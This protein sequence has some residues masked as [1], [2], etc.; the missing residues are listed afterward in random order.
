MFLSR[1]RVRYKA[2]CCSVIDIMYDRNCPR[3]VK[4]WQE[5]Q[6]LRSYWPHLF[7]IKSSSSFYM[8]IQII[9]WRNA[10]LFIIH[11][12]YLLTSF[13]RNKIRITFYCAILSCQVL[14]STFWIQRTSKRNYWILNIRTVQSFETWESIYPTTRHFIPEERNPQLHHCEIFKTCK[15]KLLMID[16]ILPLFL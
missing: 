2:R 7:Q 5:F 8:P 9:D 16:N 3:D 11:R 1:S 10:E 15:I 4:T 6:R 14:I 12:R 13:L